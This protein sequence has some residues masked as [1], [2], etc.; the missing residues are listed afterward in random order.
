MS[1]GVRKFPRLVWILLLFVAFPGSALAVEDADGGGGALNSIGSLLA[2]FIANIWHPAF[3]LISISAVVSGLILLGVSLFKFYKASEPGSNA[4]YGS[5]L[6]TMIIAGVLIAFPSAAG[7]GME[8]LLGDS[9]GDGVLLGVSYSIDETASNPSV[10]SQIMGSSFAPSSVKNC[11]DLKNNT[12]PAECMAGNIANNI[13]PAAI[14][15]LKAIVFLAGL[16]GALSA[17][18]GARRASDGRE[19]SNGLITR[20]ITSLLIM[21]SPFLLEVSTST[22]FGSSIDSTI[23]SSGF[24]NNSSLLSYTGNNVPDVLKSYVQII[25]HA[26][27]ILVFFGYWSFIRGWFMVK[28]V[29]ESG[30]QAGSYGMAAVYIVAGVLLANSQASTCV[31]ATTVSGSSDLLGGACHA[32]L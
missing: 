15:V 2:D 26:F 27:V 19:R 9:A 25:E 24:N 6:A 21:Y 18:F 28:G 31:V 3:V 13:V 30:R 10:Y 1:S 8:S 12:G 23:I 5:S 29:S 11:F 32:V 16:V 22:L 17:L 20:G 14:R 7:I 4:T